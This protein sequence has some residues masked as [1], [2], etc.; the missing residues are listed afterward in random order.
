MDGAD[1]TERGQQPLCRGE[2]SDEMLAC[3]VIW[4]SV[5]K[6]SDRRSQ[7]IRR[8]GIRRRKQRVEGKG[9]EACGLEKPELRMRV[10]ERVVEDD[11]QIGHK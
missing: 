8:P 3:S 4:N 11:C 7:I 9:R 2:L 10:V 6:R 1:L 5:E